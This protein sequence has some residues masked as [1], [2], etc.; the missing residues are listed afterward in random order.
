M[1]FQTQENRKIRPSVGCGENSVPSTVVRGGVISAILEVI[2][3]KLVQ[4]S[5]FTP[6]HT[7]TIHP[8]PRHN[9][10]GKKLII[11]GALF[12]FSPANPG[13]VSVFC[14]SEFVEDAEDYE[15]NEKIRP[16][17]GGR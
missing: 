9:L 2:W 6:L 1:A 4:Y 14:L 13:E 3:G 17:S 12:E 7:L 16:D 5:H 11:L 10:S 15:S 8:I